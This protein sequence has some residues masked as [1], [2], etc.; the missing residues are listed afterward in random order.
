MIKIVNK[1]VIFF[2]IILFILPFFSLLFSCSNANNDVNNHDL[3]CDLSPK[4]IFESNP[5]LNN[6]DL[7]CKKNIPGLNSNFIYDIDKTLT[8]DWYFID[9]NNHRKDITHELGKVDSYYLNAGGFFERNQDDK[10]IE[11]SPFF[12]L[13]FKPGCK[14]KINKIE[15]LKKFIDFYQV[16]KKI[17]GNVKQFLLKKDND[18]FSAQ[19]CSFYILMENDWIK[20][21]FNGMEKAA[22]INDING[23]C[24]IIFKFKTTNTHSIFVKFLD[25]KTFTII[26]EF[27]NKTVDFVTKLKKLYYLFAIEK[28]GNKKFENVVE[29]IIKNDKSSQKAWLTQHPWFIEKIKND[30]GEYF[31]TL[32]KNWQKSYIYDLITYVNEKI[33]LPVSD[34]FLQLNY[35]DNL[36]TN[37]NKMTTGI[38]KKHDFYIKT[39]NDS[40]CKNVVILYDCVKIKNNGKWSFPQKCT[41]K[42]TLIEPFIIDSYSKLDEGELDYFFEYKKENSNQRAKEIDLDCCTKDN[43]G[44]YHIKFW[45]KVFGSNLYFQELKLKFVTFD[46]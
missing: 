42:C 7:V 29:E 44:F 3:I 2:I 41:Y 35:H 33:S 11:S 6:N 10:I 30:G 4:I 36:T 13:K 31:F 45:L 8:K 25:N 21:K 23:F 34:V 12:R 22:K 20:F 15:D 26:S 19:N 43:E 1:K 37:G 17:D 46:S 40:I 24:G 9:K 39:L 38:G 28:I 18:F 27:L 32:K 5:V 16:Y 14:K